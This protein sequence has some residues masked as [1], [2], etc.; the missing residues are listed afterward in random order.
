MLET[1][2]KDNKTIICNYEPK[3]NGIYRV[4]FISSENVDIYIGKTE[5]TFAKRAREHINDCVKGC[6]KGSFQKA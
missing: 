6:H 2:I 3:Q 5:R 4:N 1:I